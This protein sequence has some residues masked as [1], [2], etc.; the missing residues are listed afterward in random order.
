LKYKVPEELKNGNSTV[1]ANLIEDRNPLS[2]KH[3]TPDL[4]QVKIHNVSRLV[5]MKRIELQSLFPET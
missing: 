2:Q 3:T 1:F 4:T 5:V